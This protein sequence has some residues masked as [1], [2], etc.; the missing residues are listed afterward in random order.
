[1]ALLYWGEGSKSERRLTF[2]N[3]DPEMISSY[4]YLLRKV[5]NTDEK[6]FRFVL[7]LHDYHD[8]EEMYR[9]WLNVVKIDKKQSSIYI[10]KNAGKNKKKDYKGCVS[11][12][13][14]DIKILEEIFIIIDRFKKL[15][16]AGVV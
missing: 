11:I 16:N 10:K 4:L 2:T 1:M 5:F 13:Y 8:Q 14:Y 9:Y 7:Y 15:T 12:R 6:K 3:S